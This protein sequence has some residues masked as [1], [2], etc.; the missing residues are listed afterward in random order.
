MKKI[1][2]LF[3][4]FFATLSS[5]AAG[6]SGRL[7]ISSF[8]NTNLSVVV[9]R[10]SYD[11]I[12]GSFT[13][14]DL[15]SGYHKIEVYEIRNERGFF[16]RNSSR[17]LYSSS[18]LIKPQFHVNLVINRNGEVMLREEP[19]NYRGG[20]DRNDHDRNDRDRN[21]DRDRNYSGNDDR[22]N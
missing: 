2:T 7:T 22:R 8:A 17:L 11:H 20:Y 16:K 21:D 1:S 5:F 14:D 18:V 9:D 12:P 10:N 4:L 6:P 3:I 19:I 13:I 15:R